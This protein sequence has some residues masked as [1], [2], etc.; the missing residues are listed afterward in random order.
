[1]SS[2]KI[3]Y[4]KGAIWGF[5]FGTVG[6]GTIALLALMSQTIEIITKPL[7]APS[8]AIAEYLSLNGS[9]TSLQTKVV[10]LICG[11]AYAVIGVI[12]QFIAE[13]VRKNNK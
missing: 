12:I 5:I 9:P 7:F 3:N 2:K 1:M 10:Y 6:L 11:L 8:R 4:K 13:L